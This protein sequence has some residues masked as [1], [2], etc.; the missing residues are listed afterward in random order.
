MLSITA[1]SAGAIDYLLNGSGCIEH[2]HDLEPGAPRDLDRVLEMAREP[3]VARPGVE[4]L[5]SSAGEPAAVWFGAGLEMVGIEAGSVATE[6]NVRA[7]FGQLRHPDSTAKDPVFLGR[8][9][10]IFKSTKERIAAAVAAEPDATEERVAE[11]ENTVRADGRK[12]VGYYDLTFSPVKSVSVYWAA[13]ISEGRHGE[14]AQVLQA[15]REAIG[16]AMAYAE[17]EVSY[18]RVGYHGKTS[19]GTSVGEYAKATGMVWTRWDHSTNRSQEPQMHTH[20]AVLNRVIT[21]FDGK[22]RALDG[23]GFKAVKHGIDAIYVQAYEKRLTE[24]HGVEFAERPDG[25]AREIM[26][27]D[28]RLLVAASSR[29]AAV[30]DRAAELTAQYV[31]R[32]GHEPGPAA[33]KKLTQT[34]SMATR[35]AKSHLP[36]GVQ[37]D[38]WNAPRRAELRTALEQVRECSAE[39]ARS[40]HPDQRNHGERTREQVL[41]AAVEAVQLGHATWDLGLLTT[42]IGAEQ[43]RTPSV[44]GALEEL[45]T[46]VVRN[47]A[48]YGVVGL[49]PADPAH[50]PVELRREDGKSQF[51]M[52]ET[53]RYATVS[54]LSTETGIVATARAAGAPMLVGTAVELARVELVA[55]GL[56]PDQIDAVIGILTS[57]RAGDVLIGPAG[58]GKS[59]TMGALAQTWG[60]QFGG[61]VYGLATSQIATQELAANGLNALNT[62]QFL[63]QFTP[64][65]LG[66]VER[67]IRPGDLVILDEASMCAT[68]EELAPIVRIVAAAGGKLLYT[69]DNAQLGSV[70]AGGMLNLLVADNGCYELSEVWR[71][72]H[73]WEKD[74]SIRLRAGEESVLDLYQAQGRLRGGTVEEMAA[75]AVRG[76]LADTVAG[77]ESLLVAGSN[78]QASELAGEIR[79][80][81][82]RLGRVGA[83]VIG[84]CRDG[85]LIGVGDRIQARRNDSR[86][87]FDGPGRVTN[88]ATYEVL[89]RHPLSGALRVRDEK[90]L[91]AHLP[92]DYVANHVTLAYA[93]TV[94]A[95]QGRTV[96]TAHGLIDLGTTRRAAYV[97]LT[98]GRDCNTAYVVSELDPDGHHPDRVEHT[99]RSAMAAVLG[100]V[101]EAGVAAAEMVRRDGVEESRSLGWV[102][103]QW[104]LLTIKYG[105]H[106]YTDTVH[107]LLTPEM[108]KSLVAEPGYDRL[109]RAVR[110]AELAGHNP[111]QVLT[112]AVA[113]RSLFGADSMSDVLRWRVSIQ[114]SSR[115]PERDTQTGGWA[116]LSE[117][118][119]GPVGEYVAALAAAA[120]ARQAE[121]GAR[122]AADPPQWALDRLGQLPSDQREQTEWVRRAGVIAAYRELR[123]IGEDSLSLGAAPP[124]EQVFHRAVWQQAHTALGAPADELDY[125]TA[126]DAELRQ[127]RETWARAQNWAPYRVRDELG[128]ARVAAAGYHHDAVLWAAEAALLP[129][130]SPQR[131][132][133][134]ADLG[135]AQ[136]LG[137][138]YDA[139]AEQLEVIDTLRDQWNRDSQPVALRAE[140]AGR[141]LLR[142]GLEP[143]LSLAVG[144][145]GV[146]IDVIEPEDTP[147]DR[148]RGRDIDPAQTQLE[149]GDELTVEHDEIGPRPSVTREPSETHRDQRPPRAPTLEEAIE[150]ALADEHHPGYGP[151]QPG[152]E[153]DPHQQRLFALEPTAADVAAAQPLREPAAQPAGS[154]IEEVTVGQARRE[155]EIREQLRDGR[156]AWGEAITPAHEWA[157]TH[158]PD[159]HTRD[160][161]HLEYETADDHTRQI[162]RALGREI[163]EDLSYDLEIDF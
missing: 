26:G 69:G 42:A 160:G 133:V 76:Y 23:R 72:T 84:T 87:R 121:L 16:E 138:Q 51:R 65:G 144:E 86:I 17:R 36:P 22:I 97:G 4:Y 148:V 157:Q 117:P 111:D 96:D 13:L 140:M 28:Q 15:H 107:R 108:A 103:T 162:D 163:E 119:A 99:A 85:N 150:A 79:A 91:V 116:A 10:R 35:E 27:I 74:A 18:T 43:A 64:D 57:G 12:A 68:R 48:R 134:E 2:D 126:S 31:E 5:M 40:G 151:A 90:G 132:R 128:A 137:A 127:M 25:K 50:V 59:R 100:N 94:N 155:A 125:V 161:A 7:V 67:R 20:V 82:V 145:Q 60:E 105:A 109:M 38:N 115:V 39:V 89:G 1:I 95:A 143:D 73:D 83:E 98:R 101:D 29:R 30:V 37:I 66:N 21:G 44:T 131:E 19:Q 123:N 135:R 14:A 122:V 113:A 92:S 71:F 149:L 139:R 142:R 77:K 32:H 41:M 141:E 24:W 153:V 159:A 63:M 78:A 124:R 49:G 80:D 53:E 62:T 34:A 130:G 158:Q 55:A 112:A 146:L 70:D 114:S 81:L 75:A 47:A 56:G 11:I 52:H 154:E 33:Y 129:E 8:K 45:A 6:D 120:D 46:E 9:P 106:R 54:Q 104:D 61:N 93:S 136:L 88:R 147:T 58:T 102:G 3:A 156:E 110:A 152:L 118:I